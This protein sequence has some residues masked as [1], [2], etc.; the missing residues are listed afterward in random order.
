MESK[1]DSLSSDSFEKLINPNEKEIENHIC[2]EGN[3]QEISKVSDQKEFIQSCS[4]LF[5][6]RKISN[7]STSICASQADTLSQ[8]S[9][10]SFFLSYANINSQQSEKKREEIPFYYGIKEYFVKIMPEKFTE[11]TN[12]KNYIHKNTY[13]KKK[14]KKEDYIQENIPINNYYYF[15]VIYYPINSFYFNHFSN[16]IINNYNNNKIQKENDKVNKNEE[17]NDETKEYNKE[18]DKD[19]KIIYDKKDEKNEEEKKKDNELLNSKNNKNNIINN[20]YNDN[21]K[22]YNYNYNKKPYYNNQRYIRNNNKYYNKY[23]K[24]DYSYFQDRRTSY[25]NNSN[26]KKRFQKPFE[27]KFY[28]YK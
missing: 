26:Y 7:D 16:V 8:T 28:N 24:Y 5:K 15:P 12:T 19:K 11:Y 10:S 1:I 3:F 14:T 22:N 13:F 21:I 25:Y 23:S 17:N 4:C 20:N 6:E 18:K 27:Y 9:E 2:K